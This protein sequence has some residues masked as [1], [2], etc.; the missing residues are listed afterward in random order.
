M[1]E[2]RVVVIGGGIAGSACAAAL[3]P[4]A[5]VTVV[6]RGPRGGEASDAAAGMIASQVEAHPGDPLLPLAIASRDRY[7]SLLKDLAP[8]AL[9]RVQYRG[10]GILRIA[11]DQP[12]AATLQHEVEQQRAMGLAAEWLDGDEVRRRHPGASTAITGALHAPRDAS[13][14]SGE[15][16][17]LLREVGR[18]RGATW[19]IAAA[20]M[21]ESAGAR[22]TGVRVRGA[23]GAT[24][25]IECDVVIVAAGC[26]SPLLGGLPRR[27]PIEPVRGQLLLVEAP[28]GWNHQVLF[29]PGAYVVPRGDD[30]A[31]LGSTMEKVGFDPGT[32]EEGLAAIRG[33]C[34]AMLPALAGA[35]ALHAWAGLRPVTTDALPIIGH[36]PDLTGLFYAT[37][38]GRNG[39]LTGLATGVIIRDLVLHGETQWPIASYGVDRFERP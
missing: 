9:E 21:I 20:E 13:L 36:D 30:L 32:T 29:G 35:R 12:Q 1:S 4:H 5:S 8:D 33:G 7:V 34:A 27:L 11:L 22:V 37:G 16:G 28:A 14:H 2:P 25:S 31:V 26:W 24:D 18:D 10:G 17:I 19:R 15:L 23:N 38:H 39:I 6:E 3:A